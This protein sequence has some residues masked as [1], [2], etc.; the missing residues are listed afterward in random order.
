[1]KL[2]MFNV[3]TII[4]DGLLIYNSL[5]SGI[6]FLNNEY[7][8][9]YLKLKTS[10]ECEREDLIN[11]LEEGRMIV[12]EDVD[13]PGMIKFFNDNARFDDNYLSLTLAPT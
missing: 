7:G 6:L 10:S 11:G 8:E 3:E 12:E 1:M 13:E 5:S 2:S 4:D 9:D